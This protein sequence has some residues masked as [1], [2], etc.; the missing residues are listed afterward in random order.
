MW[1]GP[2]TLFSSSRTGKR[3]WRRTSAAG[4]PTV[5]PAQRERKSAFFPGKK[6]AGIHQQEGPPLPGALGVVAVPGE[7]RRFFD[8][9]QAAAD[10]AVEE[11]GLAHIGTADDGNDREAHPGGPRSQETAAF[12]A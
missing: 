12:T 3:D 11:F 9:G 6:P 8:D 10:Q 5:R 2:S 1:V 7:P 4:A